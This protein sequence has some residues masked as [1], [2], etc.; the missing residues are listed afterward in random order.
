MRINGVRVICLY[1]LS[2][3]VE[4]FD[5]LRCPHIQAGEEQPEG[6]RW[7]CRRAGER[8]EAGLYLPL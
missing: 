2:C 3:D 5:F 8:G 7:G 6:T 4:R 1:N